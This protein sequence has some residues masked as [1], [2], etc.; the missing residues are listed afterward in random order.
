MLSTLTGE[1]TKPE[2]GSTSLEPINKNMNSSR[3]MLKMFRTKRS[4]REDLLKK[5]LVELDSKLKVKP[6]KN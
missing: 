3:K 1:S 5:K 6:E 2:E 4:Y